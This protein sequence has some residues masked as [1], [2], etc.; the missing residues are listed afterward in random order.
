MNNINYFIEKIKGSTNELLFD[1][2]EK[3]DKINLI[4]LLTELK[5]RREKDC[6]C[7]LIS[8]K[9]DVI[10]SGFICIHCGKLYTEYTGPKISLRDS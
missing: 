8:A 5:M 10:K 7:E 2:K 4:N 9:N 3:Q 1:E 6:N